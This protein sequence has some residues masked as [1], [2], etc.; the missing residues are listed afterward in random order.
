MRILL[1]IAILGIKLL[2][3]NNVSAQI[4]SLTYDDKVSI[5]KTI[6]VKL[7]ENYYF[8][9]KVPEMIA[10]LDSSLA[11][12]KYKNLNSVEPFMKAVETDL[13]S[14]ARDKHIRLKLKEN[15]TNPADRSES[16]PNL[17]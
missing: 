2:S 1:V 7:K 3:I 12:R 13:Y 16:K 11:S 5:L 8:S 4:V 15:V 9:E 14:I 6:K 10:K 17:H